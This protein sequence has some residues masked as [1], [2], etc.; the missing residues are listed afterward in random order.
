M[1]YGVVNFPQDGGHS[2]ALV[3]MVME[4]RVFKLWEIFLWPAQ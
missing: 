3:D 2:R 4:C 1:G